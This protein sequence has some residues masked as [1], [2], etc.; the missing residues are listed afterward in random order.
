MTLIVPSILVGTRREALNRVHMLKA[1]RWQIDVMDGR[2][3]P[4]KTVDPRTLPRLVKRA[5]IEAHLMVRHPLR[6]LRPL[7][8]KVDIVV[9][10]IEAL[11]DVP[12]FVRH[13]RMLGYKVGLAINP[14][15]PLRRLLKYVHLL[16]YVLV[17]TVRPGRSGQA[18]QPKQ[19][20]KVRKLRRYR[21][22]EIG[23]DG[24]IHHNTARQAARSGADILIAG[25][26]LWRST[27]PGQAK[28]LLEKEVRR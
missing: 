10:H 9:P 27:N 2:F 12:G 25:S 26:V 28:R 5:T 1:K 22:L 14:G 7:K 24:G 8:G 15:T 18:F 4:N 3:V 23:I 11:D 16:D 20:E 6:F 21:K 13:A 19:L 17:M